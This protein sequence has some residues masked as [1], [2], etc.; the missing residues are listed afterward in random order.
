[1]SLNKGIK[2]HYN[3]SMEKV[4]SKSIEIEAC[5]RRDIAD[6]ASRGI[7]IA[8]LDAM[9][10]ERAILIAI[11]S[12]KTEIES[13]TKATAD[14]DKKSG[15]IVLAIRIVRNIAKD[16]FGPK[17]ATYKAFNVK[18]LSSLSATTLYM[19]CGNIVTRAN[20]NL[21]AMEAKGLTPAMLTNITTLSEELLPLIAAAPVKKT[22]AILVTAER[23]TAAN[24]VF[25][26]TKEYCEIG[27]SCY[28]DVNKA[29]Y[30][31]YITYDTPSKVKDRKGKVA[32]YGYKGPRTND[33]ALDTKFSLRTTLGKSL[34]MYFSLKKGDTPPT[35]ALEVLANPNIFITKTAAQLGYNPATGVIQLNIYNPNEELGAF[36]VKFG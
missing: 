4:V 8:K 5:L 25:D 9:A 15:E 33:I 11:P 12:N 24:N 26:T 21:V 35:G 7:T 36:W 34:I 27:K 22:D 30:N 14:R 2:P 3:S 16:A 20:T 29:K 1:M 32:I 10:D 17:S 23:Q 31:N 6:L 28:M 18:S 13:A 19:K